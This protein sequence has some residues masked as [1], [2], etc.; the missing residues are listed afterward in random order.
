KSGEDADGDIRA[1]RE[2][3]DRIKTFDAELKT[4]EE[5]SQALA[6]WI[7]NLPHSS[8]PPGRDAA[9]NQIVRTWGTPAQFDFEPRPHWEIAT[10]LGLLDFERGPRIAGSGF[11]LF[12]GR[13]ARL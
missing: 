13:G 2:V 12:T 4:L 5:E 9:Q 8:T 7:P 11:L 10:R 1:M 6:A 3:G